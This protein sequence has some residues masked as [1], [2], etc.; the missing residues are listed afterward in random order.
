MN[1]MTTSHDTAVDPLVDPATGKRFNAALQG[2]VTNRE[3]D[4]LHK[5]SI[6]NAVGAIVALTAEV[7]MLRERLAALEAELESRKVLPVGAVENH[8]DSATAAEV[9]AA[10]LATY[11]ERVM[12]ELTRNREPVSKIDPAVRKFL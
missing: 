1:E 6:D 9:R 11:T 10:E 12:S 4:F 3:P 5:L 8:Q 2:P 7:W